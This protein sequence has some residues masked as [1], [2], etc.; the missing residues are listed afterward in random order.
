MKENRDFDRPGFDMFPRRRERRVDAKGRFGMRKKV[1][2]V[3]AF[4]QRKHEGVPC[5][6]HQRRYVLT[7][8]GSGVRRITRIAREEIE[9]VGQL[10]RKKAQIDRNQCDPEDEPMPAICL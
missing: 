6:R 9:L 5:A 8:G 1:L 10:G 2:A 4:V 3:I 7:F